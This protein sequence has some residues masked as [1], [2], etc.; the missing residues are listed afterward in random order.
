M[1]L[2]GDAEFAY[3]VQA[4]AAILP[5]LGGVGP[6]AIVSLLANTVTAARMGQPSLKGLLH[7]LPRHLL[8]LWKIT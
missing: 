1:N 3:A 2:V 7:E 6:M 4:E 8:F 5:S